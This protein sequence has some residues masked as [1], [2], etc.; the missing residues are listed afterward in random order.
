MK[1]SVM[2]IKGRKISEWLENNT[3]EKTE[4]EL[5]RAHWVWS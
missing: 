4:V 1:R 5:Q 2:E 3:K